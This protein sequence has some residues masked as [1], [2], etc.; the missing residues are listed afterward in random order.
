MVR[1]RR[2]GVSGGERH[3]EC[4]AIG[5]AEEQAEGCEGGSNVVRSEVGGRRWEGK[6]EMWA[7]GAGS[8]VPNAGRG[9]RCLLST[10]EEDGEV[11]RRRMTWGTVQYS[12][13]KANDSR[14]DT[15]SC[16]LVSLRAQIGKDKNTTRRW[17]GCDALRKVSGKR[18]RFRS[19]PR[20]L[21]SNGDS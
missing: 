8:Y 17:G 10:V 21:R 19:A 9:R 4:G 11:R 14:W 6:V 5:R 18:K 15:S 20:E 13:L 3:G 1:I 2:D 12:T 16:F 7:R